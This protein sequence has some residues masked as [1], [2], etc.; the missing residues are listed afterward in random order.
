[1][2]RRKVKKV[3]RKA[4]KIAKKTKNSGKTKAE[5]P[6]EEPLVLQ[7]LRGMKDVLPEEQCYWEQVRRVSERLARDYGFSRIDIPVVE[8]ANLFSRS[9]GEGT[10]IV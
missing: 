8:F 4:G 5:K 1:M 2:A 6:K 9:I 10:D 7:N 3:N